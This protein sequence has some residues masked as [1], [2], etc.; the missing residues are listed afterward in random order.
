M[1]KSARKEL[2]LN[3]KEGVALKKGAWTPLGKATAQKGTPGQD[4][5]GIGHHTQTPFLNPNPFQ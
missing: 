4:A 2:N 1:V 3:H 5:Q